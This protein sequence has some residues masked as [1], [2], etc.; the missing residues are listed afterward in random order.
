M[1]LEIGPGY[2][3]LIKELLSADIPF[4]HY[5][6][7]DIS[8]EN[9]RFL[10]SNFGDMRV[11]FVEGD[12]FKFESDKKFYVV[13]SSLVFK[14]VYPNFQRPLENICSFLNSGAM[15]FIDFIEGTGE[16]FEDDFVT[17]I[18]KYSKSEIRDLFD[19]VGLK[20]LDFTDVN[21][22]PGYTR[23]LVVSQKPDDW[24]V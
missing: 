10:D 8:R 3:R 4:D 13:V 16:A 12:I 7:I 9:V 6:G 1:I 15:L 23:L 17:F 5:L 22:A 19:N 2:G 18:R 24:A 20:V 14:H 11:K 21:H